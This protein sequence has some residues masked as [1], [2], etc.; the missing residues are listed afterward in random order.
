MKKRLPSREELIKGVQSGDR[1]RLAQAITL[2]ES[3]AKTHREKAQE[4]L[5]RLLPSTG[6]SIRVGITGAPGAGKSTFI[7]TLG[8]Y[9]CQKGLKTAVLAID[10]SSEVNL[11]SILGDKTRMAELSQQENCFIR[12]SPT[13]GKLGGVHRKTRETISLCEAAG[14]EVIL[15]ET[16]G[17]GQSELLIRSTV[18]IVLLLTLTGAG[19]ELQSIKKGIMEIAD[20]IVINKADGDNRIKAETA[21]KELNQALHYFSGNQKETPKVVTCSSIEG[22]GIADVWR[23]IVDMKEALR[24]S[25]KLI[26]NRQQQLIKW[27]EEDI[28]EN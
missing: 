17:V 8:S 26:K 22:N 11:G 14:H 5:R 12:P 2:I 16:V 10:P 23:L 3:R 24:V 25:G 15:V 19:D 4:V 20:L 21:A 18:D 28:I 1:V 9:L 6:K 27:L 7:N 13:S